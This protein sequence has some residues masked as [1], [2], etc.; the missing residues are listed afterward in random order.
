M[1]KSKVL[2]RALP[3]AAVS[4]VLAGCF[5][6]TQSVA[7]DHDGAGTYRVAIS[8]SGYVG[9]AIKNG[10]TNADIGDKNAQTTTLIENGVTTRT[11]KIDFHSL[12]DLSLSSE[13]IAVHVTGHSLFGL[14]ATHA[15]FRRSFRMSD[16]EKRA[17]HGQDDATARNVMASVFGNHFYQFS[18]T[19][20]GDIDWIA[21]VRI[22]DTEIK[23]SVSADGH[24]IVWRMPL[25]ELFETQS[26][27]YSVGFSTW[28]S[29]KEAQSQ[30]GQKNEN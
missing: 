6:L 17:G 10:K 4:L 21:P 22:G 20:P 16:A 30:P 2:T 19:L 9:T 1:P 11:S 14:G 12:S 3:L 27:N 25:D 26:L 24:T 13:T 15:I 23:P 7:L 18:V 5:D 29:L 28:G 8:A